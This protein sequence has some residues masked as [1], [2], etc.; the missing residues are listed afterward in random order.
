MV[1]GDACSKCNSAKSEKRSVE[2]WWC[3]YHSFLLL[4]VQ[5]NLQILGQNSQS[6]STHK[7][8]TICCA[9]FTIFL[10][11][12]FFINFF[13][14]SYGFEPI[15]NLVPC[16]GPSQIHHCM[17]LDREEASLMCISS[18]S[19]SKWWNPSCFGLSKLRF[20]LHVLKLFVVS[21]S[22]PG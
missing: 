9:L 19:N 6:C 1:D 22:H 7:V 8:F 12:P 20:P 21:L 14:Q 5:R 16:K 13:V 15:I 2:V 10:L 17:V 18:N 3:Y 11:F 4:F